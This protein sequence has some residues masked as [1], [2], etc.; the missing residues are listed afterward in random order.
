[1]PATKLER[2]VKEEIQKHPLV[3]QL[4]QFM[5]DEKPVLYK[6]V[7]PTELQI[8]CFLKQNSKGIKDELIRANQTPRTTRSQSLQTKLNPESFKRKAVV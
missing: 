1:M 7:K 3:E 2:S 6:M 4:M 8:T 5:K